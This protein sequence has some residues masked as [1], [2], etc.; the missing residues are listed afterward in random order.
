MGAVR[1]VLAALLLVGL[2]CVLPGCTQTSGRVMT[3][4][5]FAGDCY[6]SGG[7][8][9]SCDN[10]SICDE[11]QTVFDQ[12]FA[13]RKACSEACQSIYNQQSSRNALDPCWLIIPGS[14]NVDCQ[15]Y[16]RMAYPE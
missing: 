7:R 11:Y 10:I 8:R 14:A 5:E 15:R 12:T 4:S 9:I 3:W 1:F 2:L 6:Q 13:S 16:C